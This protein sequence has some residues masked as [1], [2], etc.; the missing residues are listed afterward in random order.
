[1]ILSKEIMAAE[2]DAQLIFQAG[3]AAVDPYA[4][5]KSCCRREGQMLLVADRSYDLDAFD[6]IY[7]VGAGKASAPMGAALEELLQGYLTGGVITVKYEH[8]QELATIKLTEA[9]HPLPD[10]NGQESA[11][12]IMALAQAAQANDLVIG[13]ISGGGSALLPLPVAGITL[14]DKQN[15]MSCLLSCGASIREINTLRKHISEIKGGRLAQAVYPATMICLVISDVVG[16]DLST[17]ASGPTVP[18]PSTFGDCLEIIKKYRLSG[19]LPKSV[20]DYLTSGAEGRV[21]ETPSEDASVF[22]KTHNVICANNIQ[23]IQAAQN[24][25]SSLGYNTLILSSSIEGETRDVARMHAAIAREVLISGQPLLRPACI[26][27]GGETTVTICGNGLGG[28]NQEFCL[29]TVKEID[30]WENIVILSGGTDGNDG[31]TDAAGAISHTRTAA[32]AG[33]LGIE[34]QSYLNNN[35][36]YHFFEKVGGLLRTGPTR[37]NVMDLRIMLIT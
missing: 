15:A 1:M 19:Q 36:A 9:G 27:S 34:P 20:L 26:L 37:T 24:K 16:D 2:Q 31:P 23:A 35:D 7:V 13:L 33:E 18:D 22:K 29:A 28:R 8:T 4:A 5:V 21:E 12:E 3:L 6:N 30:G 17:I 25:A 10:K 14:A 32:R 11:L